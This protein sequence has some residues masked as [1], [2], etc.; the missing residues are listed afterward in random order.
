MGFF[1]ANCKGCGHPA[2]CENATNSI[3]RWMTDVVA[4]T[5]NG[6][7]LIGPYDGYGRIGIWEET[8]DYGNSVWHEACWEVAGKPGYDGP[9]DSA[10]DQGW[11]FD[12]PDH[13]MA[14]PRLS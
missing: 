10:G 13:D 7:I 9:S 3:N 6:S 8:V 2:L 1:S 11:F 4:L 5:P 12:D 14:D